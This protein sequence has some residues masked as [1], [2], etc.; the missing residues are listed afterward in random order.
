M[1]ITQLKLM[2][3]GACQLFPL[4]VFLDPLAPFVFFVAQNLRI[5]LIFEFREFTPATA[6]V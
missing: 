1:E 6:C 5:Q 3:C 2:T 4:A